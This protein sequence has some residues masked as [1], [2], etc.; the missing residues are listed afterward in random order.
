MQLQ[1]GLFIGGNTFTMFNLTTNQSSGTITGFD[2]SCTPLTLDFFFTATSNGSYYCANIGN[3]SLNQVDPLNNFTILNSYPLQG[4]A[5]WPITDFEDYLTIAPTSGSTF[6][7]FSTITGKY[8]CNNAQLPVTFSQIVGYA[9]N[10]SNIIY[11]TYSSQT[12]TFVN[13]SCVTQNTNS[14]PNISANFS[15]NVPSGG[16]DGQMLALNSSSVFVNLVQ[17]NNNSNTVIV[18]SF[19]GNF[20][21][22]TNF[23]QA[24]NALDNLFMRLND[25]SFVMAY[26]VNGTDYLGTFVVNAQYGL[27]QTATLNLQTNLV[28]NEMSVNNIAYVGGNTSALVLSLSTYTRIDPELAESAYLIVSLQNLTIIRAAPYWKYAFQPAVQL[29]NGTTVEFGFHGQWLNTNGTIWFNFMPSFAY[30]SYPSNG[31]I[32]W[33]MYT[34]SYQQI[35]QLTT[36]TLLQIQLSTST[37]TSIPL[38]GA[39]CTCSGLHTG[40]NENYDFFLDSVSVNSTSSLYNFTYRCSTNI[41]RVF[42]NNQTSM[43]AIT[44]QS[45]V[46]P[47]ILTDWTNQ[48]LNVLDTY[49]DSDDLM[50]TVYNFTSTASSP[51]INKT[52]LCAGT[53][54]TSFSVTKVTETLATVV[55]SLNQS[56]QV[57]VYNT[58]E[59]TA[60]FN[61]TLNLVNISYIVPFGVN[62]MSSTPVQAFL[63]ANNLGFSVYNIYGSL[64]P[65]AT[66]LQQA[67]NYIPL[68]TGNNSIALLV[69]STPFGFVN[70]YQLTSAGTYTP[71]A[72]SSINMSSSLLWIAF[73][74][75]AIV[76]MI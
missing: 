72:S 2:S 4:Q 38:S 6:S 7:V 40:T 31:D 59:R 33:G 1:D 60:I 29:A 14:N 9:S 75:I 39:K 52:I 50:V 5:G 15:L 8:V 11:A 68:V 53:L 13:F 66:Q 27:T 69:N 42:I 67:T 57:L 17:N 54:G 44:D 76:S 47:V 41:Y 63:L 56:T 64:A 51:A 18:A 65:Q 10:G 20:V 36:C 62:L 73:M 28:V 43:Q 16:L 46:A 48:V 22:A 49:S 25:S 21:G 58:I 35:G 74:I 32:I 37:F 19:Q 24:N 55:S 3:N 23:N 61:Q 26:S 30:Y 71:P 12:F 70:Y 45:A 34:S